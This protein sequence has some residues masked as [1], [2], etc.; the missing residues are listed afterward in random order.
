MSTSYNIFTCYSSIWDHRIRISNVCMFD[1]KN[2]L[3]V[4]RI[5]G[6]PRTKEIHSPG[7]YPICIYSHSHIYT[8][9]ESGMLICFVYRLPAPP[10]FFM[11]GLSIW[12]GVY[13]KHARWENIKEVRY[14]EPKCSNE[15]Q[16]LIESSAVVLRPHN[17][18]GWVSTLKSCVYKPLWPSL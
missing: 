14:V 8:L 4:L 18:T 15:I 16:T 5:N 1:A 3:N 6:L 10:F 17:R 7:M 11:E 9:L 12:H 13:L 2:I